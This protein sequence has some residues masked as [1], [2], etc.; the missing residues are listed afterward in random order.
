MKNYITILILLL[1]LTA[2]RR[3]FDE[4]IFGDTPDARL[5][6]T[7]D[8]LQNRL[9]SEPGG[10]NGFLTTGT[11]SRAGFYF[12]FNNS[13]RVSM[14]SDAV[15]GGNRPKESSYR[16]KALQQPS[17]IF[18]TYSYL[19]ILA[20]PNG[21][22]NGGKDGAGLQSDFEFAYDPSAN[23][24]DS[25]VLI[26][27]MHN[28]RLVLR[29]GSRQDREAFDAAGLDNAVV[30]DSLSKRYLNY[31]K[32]FVLAGNPYELVVNRRKKS[33]KMAWREGGVY[34]E[35]MSYYFTTPS[36]N[37]ELITPVRANGMTI[38]SFRNVQWDNAR[39]L[40]SFAI[41]D[42]RVTLTP[43]A[44]PMQA[45]QAAPRRWWQK[46]KDGDTYWVSATGFRVNG[47]DDAYGVSRLTGYTALMYG[48]EWGTIRGSTTD[49]FGYIRNRTQLFAPAIVSPPNFTNDG[50]AVFT[51][52]LGASGD[53]STISFFGTSPGLAAVNTFFPAL[54]KLTEPRG[55]LFVQ[56]FDTYDMVDAVDATSWV[57]WEQ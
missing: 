51:R 16:L 28:S 45:D 46:S 52:V 36:G 3:D 27:R 12:V 25:I 30:F 56:I 41:N 24:T 34:Q 39:T 22:V 37:V 19:H 21:D 7:L 11:G 53:P 38:T 42:Q 57:S 48:A 10:W 44:E 55:Y 8:S 18:D 47:V 54:T 31:F 17:L 14:A 29:P 49:C 2:C 20:D 1:S 4:T 15:T 33:L 43:F 26:G 32:Q 23:N 50:R 13:N 35:A 6:K 5:T 40:M 9:A